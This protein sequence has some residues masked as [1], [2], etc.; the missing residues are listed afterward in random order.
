MRSDDASGTLALRARGRETVQS[1][2]EST[3]S[4]RVRRRRGEPSTRETTGALNSTLKKKRFDDDDDESDDESDDEDRAV[5]TWT[6]TIMWRA[7]VLLVLVDWTMTLARTAFRARRLGWDGWRR[8]RDGVADSTRATRVASGED[9]SETSALVT[10]WSSGLGRATALRLVREGYALVVPY[11]LGGFD[12]AVAF[13]SACRRV[14]A[15]CRVELVGPL[16]LEREKDIDAFSLRTLRRRG[17]D[18]R[19]IVHCAAAFSMRGEPSRTATVNFHHAARL[20]EVLVR[21]MMTDLNEDARVRIVFVGS[22]VHQCET[23]RRL[24]VDA[25]AEWMSRSDVDESNRRYNP[26][27]EYTWSK[28]AISAYAAVKH[29]EWLKTTGGRVR[30]VLVDP[31]L[32]DTRL[33]RE[34]PVALQTLLRVGGACLGLMQ[35]PEDAARGVVDAVNR[36]FDESSATCPHVYG[37]TG[38]LLGDSMWMREARVR[39][40]V[41][42]RANE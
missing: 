27:I 25:F 5:T 34:W 24:G 22:F 30:A 26:A 40:L 31:G 41:A 17:M 10:G 14:R 3:T 7:R 20:T 28:V 35:T 33:T 38:A 32:V 11:R 4:A 9:A 15:N 19:V 8:R 39:R 1:S 16:C 42:A 6:P 18:V 36:A 12:A 21:E 29:E 13:A 23:A 2:R 37:P